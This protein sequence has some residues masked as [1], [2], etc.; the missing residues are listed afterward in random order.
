MY[1][2]QD[3][4]LGRLVAIKVLPGL[5][6]D[7]ATL[8]R[9]QREARAASA[10][11]HPHICIVHELGEHEDRPFIVMERLQGRTLKHALRAGP[12]TAP[13]CSTSPGR[14]PTRSTRPTGRGSSTG[15]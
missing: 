8:L 15:T 7:R 14:S 1:K 9:F 5:L 6:A 13:C 3:V 12:L 10:L 4:T 11:N 2:A